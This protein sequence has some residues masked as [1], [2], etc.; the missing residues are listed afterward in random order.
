MERGGHSEQCLCLYL[1]IGKHFFILNWKLRFLVWL[2]GSI[3]CFYGTVLIMVLYHGVNIVR[4]QA[5]AW[6]NLPP[7]PIQFGCE[8]GNLKSDAVTGISTNLFYFHSFGSIRSVWGFS[9]SV[10][11]L[12]PPYLSKILGPQ[13]L[14]DHFSYISIHVKTALPINYEW[15]AESKDKTNTNVYCIIFGWKSSIEKKQKNWS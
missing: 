13:N 2:K 8:L 15:L 12:H 5:I 11:F 6:L 7:T 14:H 9:T 10:C 1:L 4:T 3:K